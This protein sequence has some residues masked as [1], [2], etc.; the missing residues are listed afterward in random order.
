MGINADVAQIAYDNGDALAFGIAN[1][2]T[3]AGLTTEHMRLTSAGFLGLGT[4]TPG[5]MFHMSGPTPDIKFSDTTG[6]EYRA[7]NNNGVWRITDDTA[8]V[9][10]FRITGAGDIG[11]GVSNPAAK[12]EVNGDILATN[13]LAG[14][15]TPTLTNTANVASS[16]AFVN[17]YMRVGNMV[18]VS[19]H[20]TITA[21]A[22]NTDTRLR[23]TL[24]I[25]SNFG[26]QAIG[27]AG[28]C[29]STGLF[30]ESIAITSDTT[31]DEAE[32]RS[33]PATTAARAYT[34]SFTYRII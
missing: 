4:N 12:L 27:G 29:T 16:S 7:G 2:S 30:G 9:E 1:S 25:A 23:M 20:V 28:A 34:F 32:F 22:A 24:P 19:G 14:T 13:L 31:N 18:T 10:R 8:A 26:A 15:Y 33:R 17:Q 3:D 6:N 11:I 5:A 21:T